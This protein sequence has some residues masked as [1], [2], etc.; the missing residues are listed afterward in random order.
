MGKEEL[1]TPSR[2]L[3]LPREFQNRRPEITIGSLVIANPKENKVAIWEQALE[4]FEVNN[5]NIAA[6]SN[7]LPEGETAESLK[8]KVQAKLKEKENYEHSLGATGSISLTNEELFE[9]YHPDYQKE[10]EQEEVQERIKVAIHEMGHGIVA[11]AL[12]GKV[13]SMSVIPASDRSRGRT[14]ASGDFSPIGSIAVA[15]GGYIAEEV[16]GIKDHRGTR[17][18]MSRVD[19]IARVW[20]L[21]E[22]SIRQAESSAHL[23]IRSFGTKRLNEQARLLAERGILF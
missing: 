13:H 5:I 18:D 2:E 11:V 6:L 8:P 1:Y 23:A 14:F 21:P 22:G 3:V 19:A 9:I 7:F 16:M 15:Y 20:G 10:M 4:G 17:G 12:G